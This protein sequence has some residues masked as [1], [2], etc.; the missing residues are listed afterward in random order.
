MQKPI[1]IVAGLLLS[2]VTNAQKIKESAVPSIVKDVFKS[3]YKDAKDIGWEKEDGNFKVEFEIGE[4]DQ[5]IVYD[6][7]GIIIE[8]EVEIKVKE[9]PSAVGDYIANNYKDKKIKEATKITSASGTVTYEA[10]IKD[11][12]LIFD[13]N[14]NFIKEEVDKDADKD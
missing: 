2:V 1:F 8:K 4:T 10:E 14:G 9:L 11:K 7:T 3:N 5:S 6:P 12:D 13:E